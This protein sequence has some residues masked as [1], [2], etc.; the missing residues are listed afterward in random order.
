ML[1]P[2][3]E[4]AQTL[5]SYNRHAF[6]GDLSAGFIVAIVALPLC[7]AFAI[8]SGLEPDKGII[9]GIV[10]SFLVAIF[11]GSHV[12]IAGPSGPFVVIAFGVLHQAGINGLI[13]ATFTAGVML[14][15]MGRAGLGSLIKFIAYPVIAGFTAGVAILLFTTEF[16][17]MLGLQAVAG[18]NILAKWQ[19][20]FSALDTINPYAVILTGGSV[21]LIMIRVKW[22]KRVPQSFLALILATLAVHIF[23]LPVDTIGS[24]FKEIAAGFPSP[25]FPQL[26]FEIVRE[27]IQPAMA[28]ALLAA[29]ESLLSAVVADGMTGT[30][31]DPKSVLVAQGLANIGS[32]LFG[33]L[34]ACAALARTAT[35][36]RNGGR[37]FVSGVIHALVLALIA[38]VL[39]KWA[40]LIPL[41]VLGAILFVVA[42][43]LFN[44]PAISAIFKNPRSDIIVLMVTLG[45]TVLVDLST[46]VLVGMALA[47][48]LFIQRMAAATDVNVVTREFQREAGV[49]R[50]DDAPPLTVPRGVEVYE[51][52][53]P[54]FFGAVYKLREAVSL[55]SKK[56]RVRM[57][58]M[59]KVNV[60]DSTGLHALEELY[61]R[62]KKEGSTLIIS[63]IHAQPFTALLKSGLLDRFGEENVTASFEDAVQ[64]AQQIVKM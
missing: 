3:L 19:A 9:T 49:P 37:T 34:P 8:A 46:G 6:M 44:W 2:K 39:G 42:Y 59:S 63:E 24:R 41:C 28:I 23:N 16:G 1:F 61:H 36:V 57:I 48:V 53:G 26:S 10:A 38:L 30:S 4:I 7:I 47:G 12:Q 29:I 35:N 33:G 18:G 60:M 56:P 32:S 17:D 52:N 13:I 31:H 21:L 20:Y 27:M 51:I 11:S 45:I 54:F 5:K 58:R 40:S 22:L 62:C 14:I 55:P 50:A 25:V 15:I 43:N 64:R